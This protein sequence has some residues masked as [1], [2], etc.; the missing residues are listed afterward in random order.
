MRATLKKQL[1][2]NYARSSQETT[3]TVECKITIQSKIIL[4]V[5]KI[6]GN[7][8]FKIILKVHEI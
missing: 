7:N 3:V 6:E 1:V 8:R 4:D 2:K 5:Y